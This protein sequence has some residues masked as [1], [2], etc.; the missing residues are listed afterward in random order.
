MPEWDAQVGRED[1]A[2]VE[3][4]Q[5]GVAGAPAG[6]RGVLF[7]SERLIAHF[8]ELLERALDQQA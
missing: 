3:R 6:D 1:A 7:R 5:Q 2:L 8:D 4:V